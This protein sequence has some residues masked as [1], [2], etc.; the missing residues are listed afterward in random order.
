MMELKLTTQFKKDLKRYKHDEDLL[1]ALEVV[2]NH[3]AQ[4][5]IVPQEY[6]PHT[7]S[8]DYKECMECHVLNDFLLIWID[9]TKPLI[10]LLRLGSH[11]ELY[12]KGRKK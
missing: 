11:S 2:L 5:G 4:N 6:F 12:G 9:K 7:L 3:L 10:K 1:K 8:G